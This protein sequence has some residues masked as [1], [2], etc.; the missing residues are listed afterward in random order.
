MQVYVVTLA[1]RQDRREWIESQLPDD[2]DVVYASDAGLAVDGADLGDEDLAGFSFFPWPLDA[3]AHGLASGHS[4]ATPM[5]TGHVGC[6]LTHLNCWR[7]ALD[8]GVSTALV[9]EDD[10]LLSKDFRRNLTVAMDQLDGEPWHLLYAGRMPIE[11]DRGRFSDLLVIPGYSRQ[12]H[13]YAVTSDGLRL[14]AEGGLEQ[15]LVN[16]DEYVPALCCDHPR[17]DMRARFPKRLN[18][19]AIDPPVAVQLVTWFGSDTLHSRTP[20]RAIAP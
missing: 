10:A 5:T 3:T 17:A 9:L 2:W 19:Y 16:I 1:R 18:A 7:H 12:T 4:Y 14:L 11:P 13:A 15:S 6:S 20:P 8:A